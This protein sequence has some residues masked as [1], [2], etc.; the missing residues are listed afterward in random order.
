MRKDGQGYYYFVDRVG[1]TFRWKGENV[2]TTEVATKISRLSRRDGS[3][4]VYG[5]TIPA[6]EGRAGMAALVLHG[7]F[8]LAASIAI[9]PITC[10]TMLAHYSCA[11][12]PLAATATFKSQPQDLN[13]G[14]L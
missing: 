5:V 12:V 2:S 7:E 9:L 4:C 14:G 8:D 6:N 1:D 3:D 10:L 11:F 13:K